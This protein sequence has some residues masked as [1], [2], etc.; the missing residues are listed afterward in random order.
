MVD[1]ISSFDGEYRWLSNFWKAQV[2][3]DGMVFPT[4]ENAY[5]AA[6]EREGDRRV[7]YQRITPWQAK[8]V[9]RHANLRPDWE[10]VKLGV[11]R[12]LV[13]QKFLRHDSLATQLFETG[14]VYIFEGNTWGDTYWG[15]CCG[16]GENNL[17]KIIM[18]VRDELKSR[19]MRRDY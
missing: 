19:M 10:D 14:D 7:L 15:V 16:E 5:Q 6:K 4:V 9:G 18:A 8:R 3:L 1:R 2:S 11:M 13:R 17:G 12:D